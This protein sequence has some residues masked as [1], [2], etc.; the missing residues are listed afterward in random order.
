MFR[1][2]GPANDGIMSGIE[3]RK[4][5]ANGTL[6]P[7]LA[8]TQA[9]DI[10]NIMNELSPV[11]KTPLPLGT[12]GYALAT[13][14]PVTDALFAGYK[15]FVKRDDARQALLDKRKQAAVSTAIG[16]QLSKKQQSVLAAEKKARFLL[17]PDA[18]PEQIRA[19]TAEIIQSEMTGKTYSDEANFRRSLEAY[20]SLYGDGNKAF[21]HAAFDEKVSPT[22]RGQGKAPKGRIKIKDGKYDTKRKTPGVYVDID[23]GKVIEITP[24]LEAIELPELSKLLI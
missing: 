24:E 2:G 23:N 16:S 21:Y 13:G 8:R 12:V 9:E 3:D 14:A 4:Q 17:P 11:K 7:D 20:R 18:T 6:N 10:I 19:K 15:D 1:R 5:L 22:L